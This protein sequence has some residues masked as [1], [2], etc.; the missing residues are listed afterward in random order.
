MPPPDAA[1]LRPRARRRRLEPGTVGLSEAVQVAGAVRAAGTVRV[2]EFFA[3]IG[4]VR[5]ALEPLGGA[6]VWANDIEQA[7][8]RTYAANHD[9]TH[10]HVKDVRQ[11]SGRDLPANLDLATSSFPCVDLS[12]AGNRQGLAGAHSGMFHEFAR[13]LSEI[14]LPERPRVVMLENVHGFATSNA[15]ADIRQVLEQLNVLGYS[16]DLLA[17]DARHFVPQ[18]RP[19]LFVIGVLD[20]H[21]L[22][23]GV[24]SGPGTLS[25]TRPLLVQRVLAQNADLRLHHRLLP[26]LPVGPATLA[27][28]VERLQP[29]DERWWAADRTSRFLASLSPVQR[30]R[31]DLWS[32]SPQPAWRTAYR[33][34]R[35]GVAVWE[36]RPDDI[37]GCLRTTGGGSSKQALVEVEAGRVR[38]RWMTPTEYASLMGAQDYRLVGSSDNQARFGFGD[39]VVVDVVRWIGEH[40]LL[41]TL[42]AR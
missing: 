6:V 38:V 33:R 12:L 4:L 23:A 26:A 8:Q 18:S 15:G 20:G 1:T 22:P 29:D 2:A 25:D 17:V 40:Y 30:D 14:P 24:A 19:R 13:V 32:Q 9:A 21:G 35:A 7:K 5:S 39:A 16:C 28:V 27:T 41:P 11:V 37:A 3:G 42:S 31:L 34:T 10:F 36:L